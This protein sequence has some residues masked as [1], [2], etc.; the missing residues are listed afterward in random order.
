MFICEQC[1][2]VL[3]ILQLNQQHPIF[4][5]RTMRFPSGLMGWN[6][7]LTSKGYLPVNQQM[8]HRHF[9]R[10]CS[11]ISPP[12]IQL[13]RILAKIKK[14]SKIRPFKNAHPPTVMNER[15]ESGTPIVRCHHE[16]GILD[17][18]R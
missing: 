3:I 16:A 18:Y 4:F 17:Q 7:R 5:I 14:L 8:H 15:P 6:Q 13:I 2:H 1:V 10:C 12:V 9:L 11:G